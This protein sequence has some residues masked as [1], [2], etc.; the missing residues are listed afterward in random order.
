M[1]LITC[2]LFAIASAIVASNKG[3]SKLGWFL[4]GLLLGPFSLIF[5]LIISKKEDLIEQEQVKRGTRKKCPYCAELVRPEAIKCKH[6]GGDIQLL[7]TEK[8]NES[9][10]QVLI[11]EKKPLK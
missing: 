6:C 7:L 2:I 11:G 1:I 3:R 10:D 8:L 5:V 9:D 4:M